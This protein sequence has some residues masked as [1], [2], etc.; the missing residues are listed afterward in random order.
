M[1]IQQSR[2]RLRAAEQAY[3]T[4]PPGRDLT[5]AREELTHART[6][7]RLDCAELVERLGDLLK[8]IADEAS[9]WHKNVNDSFVPVIGAMRDDRTGAAFTVG[10]LRALAKL[11]EEVR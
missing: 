7:Y 5:S 4:A 3:K 6:E 11:Y 9:A 10:D 8:P 1:T 2:A